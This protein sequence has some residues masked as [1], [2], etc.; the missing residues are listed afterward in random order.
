M[1]KRLRESEAMILPDVV[2]VCDALAPP[3]FILHSV[4][5]SSDGQIYQRLIQYFMQ[6]PV[7]TSRDNDNN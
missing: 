6:F 2:A 4:L 7:K 1:K 3:D 5:G